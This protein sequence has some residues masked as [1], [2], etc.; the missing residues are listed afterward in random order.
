MPLK[1]LCF[2]ILLLAPL[3]NAHAKS[4]G[5]AA[6]VNDGVISI[7]DLQART[8][9][10]IASSG[11]PDTQE[12]RIKLAPQVIGSLID[13]ELQFQEAK[14][15]NIEATDEE[16]NKEFAA[17][18]AMNK[19]N[20]DEF[21]ERLQKSGANIESFKR[22]MRARIL[23]SKIFGATLRNQVRVNDADIDAFIDRKRAQIGKTEYHLSEIL[24]GVENQK[25]DAQVQQLADNVIIDLRAG[26]VPFNVAAQ[27]LSKAPGAAQGGNL[28][29][30]QAGQLDPPVAKVI[31]NMDENTI[32]PPI[33]TLAGYHIFLLKDTRVMTE[34]KIPSRDEVRQQIGLERSERVSEN[35]LNNLRSS[36]FID[37]RL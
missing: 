21:E 25:D 1:L 8:D 12:T 3:Q 2:L 27:Q 4:F 20:P 5:I 22:Q 13:E 37:V 7:A 33:K 18:A 15:L 23:W 24:L 36:A 32:S 17:V 34:D 26:K 10:I 9:L 19:L 16:I 6:T 35:H 31:K 11:L 29:W 28:G 30:I 14:R